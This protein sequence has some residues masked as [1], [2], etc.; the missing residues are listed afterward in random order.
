MENNQHIVTY[1]EHIEATRVGSTSLHSNHRRKWRRLEEKHGEIQVDLEVHDPTVLDRCLKWK[2]EQYLRSGNLDL[3]TRPWARELAYLISSFREPQFA[4]MLSVLRVDGRPIAA[5]LGIRSL[6]FWHY[7][8][9][10]YDP[11]FQRF[12]PGILLLLKMIEGAPEIGVEV[13]DFGKGENPYKLRLFNHRTPLLEGCVTSNR[14]IWMVSQTQTKFKQLVK[15]SPA[16]EYIIPP[17][18]RLLQW[19]RFQ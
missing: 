5:H 1:T 12:S 15:S 9:P 19:A 13:I 17:M 6:K 14:S 7:W 4:G 10:S 11:K 2:S 8:F 3:F 18:R 16:S